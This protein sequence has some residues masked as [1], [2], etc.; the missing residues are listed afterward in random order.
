MTR[1]TRRGALVCIGALAGCS[2]TNPLGGDDDVELDGAALRSVVD[3]DDRQTVPERVPVGVGADHLAAS[4]TRAR[5]LIEAVPADL[6]PDEI[7]NGAIRERIRRKRAYAVESLETATEAPTPFERL[8]AF[9]DARAE[10]RFAAGAWRAIDAGLTRDDLTDE[11][12]AVR[13]DRSAFRERWRYLGDDPVV[14][15]RVHA[16]IERRV[17]AGRADVALGEPRHYRVGN[18]LGVGEVAEEIERARVAVSDAA[19]LYDRLTA[20]VDDPTDLRPRFVDARRS[21]HDAF[22]AERDDLPE[23][24]PREPWSIEGVEVDDTPAQRA[25][26]ELYRPIDPRHDDRWDDVPPA[27]ALHWAHAA[28]VAVAAFGS[29]RAR[30]ADGERFTVE[31]VDDVAAMRR[32]AVEAV[33]SAAADRSVLTRTA[34]TDAADRLRHTDARL[35]EVSDDT[36]AARIRHEVSAYPVVTARARA[37]PA[38]SERVAGVLRSG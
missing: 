27:R 12:G 10:A 31:S 21:L 23:I 13:D 19:H 3:A 30:V 34:L 6:G 29:L 1:L 33:R 11:A 2:T 17:D 37:I 26:D 22:E 28:L 5:S 14:A 16:E 8:E 15:M 38:A 4:E 7:P 25:L 9:A 18:P 35:S 24:D 20:S 36:T 32:E